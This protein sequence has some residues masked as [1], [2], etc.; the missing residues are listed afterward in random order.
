MKCDEAPKIT[1]VSRNAIDKDHC[2]RVS[3]NLLP[4]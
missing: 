3:E 4:D 2:Q 1:F